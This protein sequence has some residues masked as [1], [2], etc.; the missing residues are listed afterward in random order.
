M[1]ERHDTLEDVCAKIAFVTY[2]DWDGANLRF[3]PAEEPLV[4]LTLGPRTTET[5]AVARQ[6]KDWYTELIDDYDLQVIRSFHPQDGN[7]NASKIFRVEVDGVVYVGCSFRGSFKWQDWRTDADVFRFK[8]A[9]GLPEGFGHV[10]HGLD[11]T[12]SFHGDAILETLKNTDASRM[13]CVGHSLGG[14]LAALCAVHA[15]TRPSLR[16][17]TVEAFCFGAPRMFGQDFYESAA[18]LTNVELRRICIAT[19]P[20][21]A[22][23]P[24][25]VFPGTTKWVVN[26]ASGVLFSHTDYAN[27]TTRTESQ[28]GTHSRE[29]PHHDARTHDRR[30]EVLPTMVSLILPMI[31]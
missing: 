4:P 16:F 25:S 5:A 15:G 26:A 31:R 27:L 22:L 9:T 19:D 11:D 14:A 10:S 13:L 24:W 1:A 28:S 20:I 6:L 29:L 18:R 23:P 21:C 8:L 30:E 17:S 7:G 3:P 12:Y 2:G